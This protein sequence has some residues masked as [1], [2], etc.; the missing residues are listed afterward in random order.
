MANLTDKQL[1]L[2][3]EGLDVQSVLVAIQVVDRGFE[4]GTISGPESGFVSDARKALLAAFKTTTGV[5]YDQDRIDAA[6][7]AQAAQA[8]A[9][10]PTPAPTA[11]PVPTGPGVAKVANRASRKALVHDTEVN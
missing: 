5:D 8:A 4:R 2:P 7:A 10:A 1:A 9:P 3:V 6:K 11:V